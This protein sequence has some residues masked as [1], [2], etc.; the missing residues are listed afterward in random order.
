M[1]NIKT[2]S[3][4]KK[5]FKS[6]WTAIEIELNKNKYTLILIGLTSL[7]NLCLVLILKRGQFGNPV[8]YFSKNWNEYEQG[9]FRTRLLDHGI[10]YYLFVYNNK[11]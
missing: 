4:E 2:I 6:A 1:P 10:I 9:E 7:I 8:D 11:K 5:R 3:V